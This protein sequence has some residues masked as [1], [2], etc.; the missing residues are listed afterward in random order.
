MTQEKPDIGYVPTPQKLLEAMLTLAKV[1]QDDI[2]YDLGSGDGRIVITA[3]Q[4]Y[5]CRGVGIE[6]DPKRIREAN[7]N[8]QQAR[9][10][11]QV[12]FRQENLFECNFADATVVIIYLMPYLNL[13]LRPNLFGQ[14]KPGT[15]IVSRDFDMEDWKP[16]QVL[17]V[18]AEEEATLYYWEIPA[19]RPLSTLPTSPLQGRTKVFAGDEQGKLRK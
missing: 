1:K 12:E 18:E 5:G 19:P 6:I 4:K 10:A 7:F 14:L 2:I 13:R 8:A 17:Q 16:A 11:A 15:R 3:A 9:V